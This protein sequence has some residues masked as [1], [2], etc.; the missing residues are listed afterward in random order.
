MALVLSRASLPISEPVPALDP[1]PVA[2]LDRLD[3]IMEGGEEDVEL[4]Q[5]LS[6]ACAAGTTFEL[7]FIV[8]QRTNALLVLEHK[9]MK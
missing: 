5:L 3:L 2:V 6:L 1:I 9:P 8:R 7:L 4:P